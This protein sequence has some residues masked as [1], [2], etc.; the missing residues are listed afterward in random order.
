MRVGRKYDQPLTEASLLVFSWRAVAASP[1]YLDVELD[2]PAGPFGTRDYRIL[3]EAVPLEGG[4]TFIHMGYA[5]GYGALGQ[6]AMSTYL[7]TIGRDKVGFTP[8]GASGS[9]TSAEREA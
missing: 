7:G 5:F 4:R 9:R 1:E 2:A 6:L 3:L 8:A